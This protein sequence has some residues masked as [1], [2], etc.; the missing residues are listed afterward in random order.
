MTSILAQGQ[1]LMALE[2]KD[3]NLC[4]VNIQGQKWSYQM[5]NEF[6]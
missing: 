3:K 2:R 6:I 5:Q 4:M 1:S